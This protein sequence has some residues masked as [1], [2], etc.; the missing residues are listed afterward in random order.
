MERLPL[1]LIHQD[2]GDEVK[3]NIV[4]LFEFRKNIEGAT[5]T[6]SPSP[7][8]TSSHVTVDRDKR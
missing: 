5:M 7:G 4:Y 6:S 1:G 8:H 2:F 3:H